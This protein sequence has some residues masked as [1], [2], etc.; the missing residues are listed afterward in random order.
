MNLNFASAIKQND[1]FQN[2]VKHK[3]TLILVL[4]ALMTIIGLSDLISSSFANGQVSSYTLSYSGNGSNVVGSMAELSK[5]NISAGDN[6]YLDAS[7]YS[8]PGYGFAGWS[9]DSEA[10]V[11]NGATIYGPRTTIVAPEQYTTDA[12]IY[13]VWVPVSGTLQS[14]SARQCNAMVAA[15]YDSNTQSVIAGSVIA[16]EDERDGNVYTVAKLADD[17][18]WTI[19]N[20]RLDLTNTNLVIN[21]ENTN[22]PAPGFMNEVAEK[23]QT[24]ETWVQCNS[25][26]AECYNQISFSSDN[27]N[28][29]LTASPKW[30][31]SVGQIGANPP[32]SW[33]SYG[34]IYNYY[35][36]TAGN[37]TFATETGD[38]AGD[39]CPASWHMPRGGENGDYARMSV[40]LGGEVSLMENANT[41]GSEIPGTLVSNNLRQYPNNILFSGYYRNTEINRRSTYGKYWSSTILNKYAA[42]GLGLYSGGVNPGLFTDSYHNPDGTTHTIGDYNKSL[43]YAIRCVA[44]DTITVLEIDPVIE[45]E[46]NNY[47]YSGNAIKPRVT[48]YTDD[49]KAEMLVEGTDYE[50]IYGTN[51]NAGSGTITIKPVDESAYTFTEETAEFSISPFTLTEQNVSYPTSIQYTGEALSPEV[52]VS[53]L[54]RTLTEGTDYTKSL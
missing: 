13:A 23:V 20:L 15:T 30:S 17:N 37:V 1:F 52:G 22:N 47:V 36:A 10:T 12:K 42:Y 34:G 44:D 38:A 4:S 51:I 11:S 29:S 41:V 27:I 35:T 24:G 46:D 32:Y 33:W 8:R 43:G 31:D 7:N 39:L 53:A 19:E 28:R 2:F 40:A 6:I 21:S 48:V 49:S 16:L 50:L 3:R 25:R 9:F 26:T 5:T 14:F 45:I 54:G 18:C